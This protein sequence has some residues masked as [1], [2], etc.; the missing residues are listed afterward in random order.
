[1]VIGDGRKYI[2]ALVVPYWD[3]IVP[4]L[5]QKGVAF[6]ENALRYDLVNG[7]N[8]CVEVGE[9]LAEHPAVNAIVEEAVGA[10]NER[11]A[12]FEM[13]KRY[14]ILRRKFLQ[15]NDELTPTLKLKSKVV[16]KTSE[17]RLKAFIRKSR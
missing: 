14:R 9:D 13:I 7:I 4:A 11:L 2:S 16:Q 5:K 12:D 8:S 17:R 1:M 10:A 6:D 15:S 3:A